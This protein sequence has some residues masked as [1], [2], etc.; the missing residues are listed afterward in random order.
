MKRF[1]ITSLLDYATTCLSEGSLPLGGRSVG[2]N[3]VNPKIQ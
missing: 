1:V 2:E 3:P